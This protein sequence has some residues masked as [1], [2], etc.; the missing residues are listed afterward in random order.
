MTNQPALASNKRAPQ[1]RRKIGRTTS[2]SAK[3]KLD[4]KRLRLLRKSFVQIEQQGGIAGLIFYQTLFRSEPSLKSLF[5][6]SI[7]L[8][9]RKLME[10]LTYAV[11]TLEDPETLIPVLEALGRRHVVYGVCDHHY[12]LVT[13][14]L[15]ETFREILGDSFTHEVHEAWKQTLDFVANTMKQGAARYRGANGSVHG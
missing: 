13:R 5:Q 2:I 8:Q 15:I 11:A 4:S 3:G 7:D 9:S 12:D 10:S 14:A 1:R 6:T